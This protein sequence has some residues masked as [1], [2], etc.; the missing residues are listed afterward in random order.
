[1]AVALANQAAWA[2]GIHS[3]VALR[4]NRHRLHD[5]YYQ[6]VVERLGLAF[7]QR[8]LLEVVLFVFVE[9]LLDRERAR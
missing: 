5:L 6:D 3:V 1:M 8:L 7:E 9:A 2:D 4:A